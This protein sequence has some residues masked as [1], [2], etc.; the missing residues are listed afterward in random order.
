M[1]ATLLDVN[2]LIALAWPNH[3]HHRAAH[4]W[5]GQRS[6]GGWATCPMTQCAFVRVSSNP[7]ILEDAVSP[8]EA[9]AL[10]RRMLEWPGHVFWPDDLSLEGSRFHD[11][12]GIG[13]HRQITDAYLLAL[14]VKHGGLLA[15]FDAGISS[16]AKPGGAEARA[17]VLVRGP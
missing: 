13:G 2:L 5:F 3:L 9:L 8:M 10:L 15:T 16:L 7:R 4:E 6:K 11:A 17:V 14:A 1:K 12:F